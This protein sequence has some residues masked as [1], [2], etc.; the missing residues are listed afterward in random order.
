MEPGSSL[1][2]RA[3]SLFPWIETLL[4]SLSSAQA[5]R[6]RRLAPKRRDSA[7]ARR[8]VHCTMTALPLTPLPRP[9][10][11]TLRLWNTRDRRLEEFS[12][13]DGQ[14]VGLYTCGPTVYRFVH[15]GNLRTYLMADWLRRTLDGLGHKVAHVKNIRQVEVRGNPSLEVVHGQVARGAGRRAASR[16][17]PPSA[18][19]PP[20]SS[21]T[22]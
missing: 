12:R 16:L 17:S 10:A 18:V 21:S 22:S 20:Y 9:A 6:F 8:R 5:P 19:P 7:A 11:N 4:T 13:R 15:I 3:T 2:T 14:P 1:D